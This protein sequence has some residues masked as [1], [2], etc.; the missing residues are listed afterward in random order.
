MID[1]TFDF[2]TDTTNYWDGYWERKNGLGAGTL[3][4]DKHSPTLKK[5]HQLLWSKR[6]PNGEEMDLQI[7]DDFSHEDFTYLR[8]K[9]FR[10]SSDTI[11]VELKY[12]K[13]RS[14]ID[15]VM[16]AVGDYKSYYENLIRKGYTIGGT[17]IFPQHPGSINQARG[18]NAFIS[19]RWDLTL[20]CIRRYYLGDPSP[21]SATIRGDA[22]FFDLFV[23]F[24]GYVD[25]FFL[26]D[27]VNE[28]YSE[29]DIWCGDASFK[30]SG[31]PETVE[32][33]F[34]FIEKQHFFLRNRATTTLY[35]Y[36][37]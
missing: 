9:D 1:V 8:W 13:Y 37:C 31:L 27:C 17:I 5:Y 10:L 32:D 30:K 21:I 19:D 12:E 2:T 35:F 28:D 11:I 36:K 18:T 20:E 25:F 29:V 7:G 4:P 3:D 26:Q 16:K 34:Q 23:D 24:K 33:Y 22:D 14:V 15:K 6:L